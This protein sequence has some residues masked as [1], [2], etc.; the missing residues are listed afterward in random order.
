MT[1]IDVAEK[2]ALAAAFLVFSM[3]LLYLT[4]RK[5]SK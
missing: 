3:R 4:F 5:D 2:I 1:I